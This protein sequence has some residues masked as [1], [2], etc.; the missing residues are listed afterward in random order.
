MD[1]GKGV[2]WWQWVMHFEDCKAAL[3]KHT[4]AC[5]SK[6]PQKQKLVLHFKS[7]L[8]LAIVKQIETVSFP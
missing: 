5:K 6:L 8:Y 3:L 7:P 1:Y 2:N 4:Q